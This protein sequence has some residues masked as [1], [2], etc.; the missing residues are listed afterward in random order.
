[1]AMR[2]AIS[3][4]RPVKR[5]SNKFATL[6]HA[7]SNTAPTAAT[8]VMKAGRKLPVTSS[9]A[10]TNTDAQLLSAFSGRSVRYP[11]SSAGIVACAC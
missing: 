7:M 2:N 3:R 9:A 5:T 8:R 6:L 11:C 10:G 4:R 1:M